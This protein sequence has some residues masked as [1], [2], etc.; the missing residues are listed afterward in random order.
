MN[1]MEF[2]SLRDFAKKEIKTV[3]TELGIEQ[4]SFLSDILESSEPGITEDP[5]FWDIVGVTEFQISPVHGGIT[6]EATFVPFPGQEPIFPIPLVDDLAIRFLSFGTIFIELSDVPVIKLSGP[7]LSLRLPQTLLS[8]EPAAI[9]EDRLFAELVVDGIGQ[10]IIQSDGKVDIQA[11]GDEGLEISALNTPWKVSD[12]DFTLDPGT[13]TISIEDYI[14]SFSVNLNDAQLTLPPDI[15]DDNPV[16]FTLDNATINKKGL[17]GELAVELY[18]EWDQA[19][20]R[21]NGTGAA[22]LGGIPIG[23]QLAAIRFESNYPVG[24]LV[25]SEMSLPFF[26]KGRPI[27]EIAIDSVGKLSLNMMAAE[28][29]TLTVEKDGVAR[30]DINHIG[31]DISRTLTELT[32][33][34]DLIPTLPDDLSIPDIKIKLNNLKV[35]SNG[36][37][38]LAS[39]W[40]VFEPA[41]TAD[42]VGFV[43]SL[44]KI[45]IG[46]DDKFWIAVD[47]KVALVDGLPSASVIGLKATF[48]PDGFNGANLPVPDL[49]LEG[50]YLDASIEETV[51][52]KGGGRLIREGNNNGFAGDLLLGLPQLGFSLDA[53]MLAGINN[54]SPAYPYLYLAVGVELPVGIPL[55]QSGLAIFGVQ[56]LLGLNIYPSFEEG[57]DKSWYYDWYKAAP[58][59]GVTHSSKWTDRYLGF[60]FGA[61]ITLGTTD[62]YTVISRALLALAVPGP[63]IIVEGRAAFLASRQTLSDNPPLRALMILDLAADTRSIQLFIEAQYEF[64]EG[65]MFAHGVLEVFS[66]LKENPRWFINLGRK[67]PKDKRIQAEILKKLVRGD[68]YFQIQQTGIDFGGSV[69]Y[70]LGTKNYGPIQV[71]LEISGTLEGGINFSP[72]Q[73]AALLRVIGRLYCLAWGIGFDF[74]V[75]VEVETKVP[76]PWWLRFY[77]ELELNLPWPLPDPVLELERIYEEQLP[78][79]FL[80]VLSEVQASGSKNQKTWDLL[81]GARAT[82]VSVD[83]NIIISMAYRAVNNSTASIGGLESGMN[84]VHRV[85]EY[86]FNYSITSLELIDESSGEIASLYGMWQAQPTMNPDT[87]GGSIAL[88]TKSTFI[89][90]NWLLDNGVVVSLANELNVKPELKGRDQ[91]PKCIQFGENMTEVELLSMRFK[92]ADV[93][94]IVRQPCIIVEHPNNMSPEMPLKNGLNILSSQMADIGLIRKE[95]T[96]FSNNI[97]SSSSVILELR[98]DAA[99]IISEIEG[100]YERLFCTINGEFIPYDIGTGLRINSLFLVGQGINLQ[101][102]CYQEVQ[103]LQQREQNH[104]N[105][106]AGNQLE[107]ALRGGLYW[108]EEALVLK[109]E[110][111]YQLNIRIDKSSS[112][113]NSGAR[114]SIDTDQLSLQFSTDKTPQ[115]LTPYIRSIKAFSMDSMSDNEQI[116]I[117]API[118]FLLQD[119]DESYFVIYQQDHL[120]IF[121]N[122][123]YVRNMYENAADE[124]LYISI[125]DADSQVIPNRVTEWSKANDRIDQTNTGILLNSVSADLSL[126]E[127]SDDLPKDDVLINKPLLGFDSDGVAYGSLKSGSFHTLKI[128]NHKEGRASDTLIYETKFLSSKFDSWKSLFNTANREIPIIQIEEFGAFD[129]SSLESLDEPSALPLINSPLPLDSVTIFIIKDESNNQSLL[130]ME[131]PEAISSST[132]TLIWRNISGQIIPAHSL[133]KSDH[134]RWAWRSASFNQLQSLHII[135]N[136]PPVFS[137]E[138]NPIMDELVIELSLEAEE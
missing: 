1:D 134:T 80:P 45:G 79:P 88:L 17:T 99:I 83:A 47:G 56:G 29:G 128:L 69:G 39:G 115:D 107:T 15:E 18:P 3:F 106:T 126:T 57:A 137:H 101:K 4:F 124:S 2:T 92:R 68:A 117:Q 127:N 34:G 118:G 59:D 33:S 40:V 36:K 119:Y 132:L 21:F 5:E 54:N 93:T 105:Q 61:G 73:M 102:L 48:D 113:S 27:I 78:P 31:L 75:Q 66:E 130:V 9:N 110:T 74:V 116:L 64:V 51:T 94:F 138:T 98:W 65:V 12:S 14:D 90:S 60:A 28:G 81:E 22:E 86:L 111:D 136:R 13:I 122:E 46:F 50:I 76:T 6:I 103:S 24:F 121:F 112:P 30:V 8:G 96:F 135:Y 131:L 87:S 71:G 84:Y 72:E 133:L 95:S 10:V 125:I 11:I 97:K 16:T 52:I 53:S 26:D 25:R 114:N 23:I 58:V 108:S 19:A 7:T 89:Y 70:K 120:H 42:L 109:P 38:S 55:G 37:V 20:S 77:F 41:L 67:D 35:D 123:S 43:L 44:Y 49:S 62:G 32:F 85:G 100:N 104:I 63:K 82:Q 129:I 91:K